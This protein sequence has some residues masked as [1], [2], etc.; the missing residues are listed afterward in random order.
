MNPNYAL[1]EYE[2]TENDYVEGIESPHGRI[3]QVKILVFSWQGLNPG[4]QI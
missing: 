4:P 2:Q 1:K 3:F